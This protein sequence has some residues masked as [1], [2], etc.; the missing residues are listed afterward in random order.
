MIRPIRTHHFAAVLCAALAMAANSDQ[1][2][3]QAGTPI[4]I[5]YATLQLPRPGDMALQILTPTLLE[6]VNI[7]TKQPDPATVSNWDFIDAAGN[8]QLPAAPEFAVCVNGAPAPVSAVGFKRRP[9]YAPLAEYDLRID[10]RLYLQL[11]G[12]IQPGQSVTVLNPGGSLWSSGVVLSGTYSPLQ[13]SPAI[14]VNQEGYIA[15][16]P[17]KAMVGYYLG[18]LGEMPAP[19]S[20]FSLMDTVSGNIVFTGTLTSRPDIGWVYQA[21]PYQQVYQADFSG[22]TAPGQYELMVPGLGASLPFKID[23]Q[24]AMDFTRA[25]ALGLYH[26]R[27]GA[28]LS[29]PYTRFT[30]PACHLAPASIPLPASAFSNTWNMIASDAASNPNPLQTAAPL[31]SP[32]AMLYPY[33]RTGFVDVSGG[34]HD[35]GDYSKYTIDSA[36]LIH[37]LVFAADNFPNAGA[38]DNLGIPESGD[39]NSDLLQEAKW[40]ADFLAKMQDT[41][42]GFYFLVYPRNRPYELNVLPQNGDPQVVWPKNT[43]ATASA[44]AALAEAA[45]SPLFKSEFPSSAAI[46][47]R[48]AQKGWTFLMNAVAA[49]GVAGS[50]QRMTDYGDTF[51]GVDELA[52]AAAAMYAATGDTTYQQYLFQWYNP[53]DPATLRW[54]WWRLYEGYGCAARTYAF[55]AH[56]GRL[57]AGQLDPGYLAQCDAQIEAA[58]N[59]VLTRTQD[60]AYGTAFDLESKRAMTAGWYFGLDRSFDM[61]VAY[62]LNPNPQYVDAI[63]SNMNYEGGCN[64]L[65][66]SYLTGVGYKRQREIVNQFSQNDGRDMPPSGLPL[67]EIQT[68]LPYL[69]T[70]GPSLDK[71]AYPPDGATVNPHP[72]YDR[73]SDTYNT[74]TEATV[75]NQSRALAT[76]AFLAGQNQGQ[77]QS[78]NS[79][80]A[81]INTPAGYAPAG[82][83]VTLTL[84][85]SL[86]MTGAEIVWEIQG[87]EPLRG[88]TTCVFTPVSA[89]SLWVE[90]EVHWIDGRRAF[91]VATLPVYQPDGGTPFQPDGHTIALYHFNGNFHDSGAN[92]LNLAVSGHAALA[93]G[94]SGWS[95]HP[96]GDAAGFQALGD[97]LTVNIPD[98]LVMPGRKASPLSIEAYIYPRG[99]LAYGVGNYPV[100]GLSQQ[101]DSSLEVEDGKWNSP[102]CPAAGAGQSPILTSQQWCN[103]TTLNTWHQLKLTFA[104]SGNAACWIDGVQVGAVSGVKLNYQRGTPWTFTLGNFNGDIAEVRVSNIVR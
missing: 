53:D 90:A 102:A 29:L 99:Y 44:V 39:G 88:G 42:G 84:Q 75:V 73:W 3:Q 36:Q 83:P 43:A 49:R 69:T 17:K 67:G 24:I 16:G 59:D 62:Q 28:A 65:N 20:N 87:Q 104:K 71:L 57:N 74:T 61:A 93:A 23:P 100:V 14:H 63:L 56:S 92:H 81:R 85:S 5:D 50:Y 60:S 68:G 37:A 11:A 64:P 13:F 98:A 1:A 70:Y 101:W 82:V 80:A 15:Q 31:T 46:Y 18:T 26:Q 96:T 94:N 9:L 27:C 2:P 4:A 58:G 33:V 91:A 41:D 66:V 34:H 54:T 48:D 19:S 25:Y 32:A 38:L 97:A 40:E 12:A 6:I 35:A 10:N 51:A 21:A 103:A 72:F 95:S 22:F 79:G 30:H 47:M 77:A 78:W 86:D 7:N 55:A 76:L 89:G 8:A 52:W 45:S